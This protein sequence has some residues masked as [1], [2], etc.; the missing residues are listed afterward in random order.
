MPGTLLKEKLIY[1]NLRFIDPNKK[2][3]FV[4]NLS[5]FCKLNGLCY[6]SMYLV[7]SEKCFQY[8]GWI[9]E[10]NKNKKRIKIGR[11]LKLINSNNQIINI[12]NISQ[13]CRDFNIDRTGIDRLLRQEKPEH[14]GYKIL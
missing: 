10:K 12:K 13:F 7:A 8:K 9:L 14:K 4:E 11:S 6:N 5:Q 1:K 3:H 2:R